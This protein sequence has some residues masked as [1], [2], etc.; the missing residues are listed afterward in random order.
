[1]ARV[2]LINPW[3][4]DEERVHWDLA[5][6]MKYWRNPYGGLVQL[7]SYLRRE[8]HST[9]IIDCERD[10]LIEADGNSA[11]LLAI[12]ESRIRLLRPDV[13]GV[14]GMTYRYPQA[15]RILERLG[16]I[17]QELGF[18]LI[19]GGRHAMGEPVRCLIDSP[20]LDCVFYGF[21]E[22]GLKTFLEGAPLSQVPGIVYRQN[23]QYVKTE[24]DVIQDLDSLPW[25]DWSLIDASFYS[26][27]NINVHRSAATPLRSLDTRCSR[28]CVNACAFCAGYDGRPVWN[29]VGY[30]LDQIAWAQKTFGI[31]ATIF[32]DTSLGNNLKFLIKLCESLIRRG[33][34]R[35]LIWTANMTAKQVNP[36]IV[37]LMYRA[38]CR[39]V[40]IGFESG[41]NRVLEAM[42]K[43]AMAED[44]LACAR[45]LE[46]AGMPYWASFIAGYPGE[47]ESDMLE[48]MALIA[49]MRPTAGWV[50]SFSPL[51][52]SKIYELLKSKKL[53]KISSVNDWVNYSRTGLGNSNE[54]VW[55]NMPREKF[56]YY[57]K[58]L[59]DRL[60]KHT[61]EGL[62]RKLEY[63]Q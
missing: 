13:V 29:S 19:M 3:S 10:L 60:M 14:T 15:Y 16:K 27:P 41:S 9:K 4:S 61:R 40:F 33:M 8:K 21:A 30:V 43:G 59:Q 57:L 53:I 20:A 58:L 36:E 38:G 39:M 7:A 34:H 6:Q 52:G 18:K 35:G 32:Q 22:I 54:G 37:K 17:K 12:I 23:G 44:N 55:A 26:Y 25:P 49:N 11:I 50:N 5:Y 63:S 1:M 2:V 47:T 51:P 45:I 48:T 62:Q 56:R 42:R 24:Q 46:Q 28:G 31:N